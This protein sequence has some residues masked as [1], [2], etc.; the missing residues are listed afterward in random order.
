MH[1]LPS[2]VLCRKKWGNRTEEVKCA[3][4]LQ[5]Q[6]AGGSGVHRRHQQTS[7][8]PPPGRNWERKC[9]KSRR[10]EAGRKGRRHEKKSTSHSVQQ[11]HTALLTCCIQKHD[12]QAGAVGPARPSVSHTPHQRARL[13]SPMVGSVYIQTTTRVGC[14]E[15]TI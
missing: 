12:F 6:D 4:H 9:V 10:G 8:P 5:G 3:V 15:S 11:N 1:T 2:G 13:T 7:P 14:Q